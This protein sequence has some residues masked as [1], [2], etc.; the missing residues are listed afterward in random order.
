LF[1]QT[2]YEAGKCH[3]RHSGYSHDNFKGIRRSSLPLADFNAQSGEQSEDDGLFFQTPCEAGKC[4]HRH[5]GYS[6][7]NKENK[8]G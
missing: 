5:S 8:E 1:F 3:H 6:P 7:Y 4:H 2:P